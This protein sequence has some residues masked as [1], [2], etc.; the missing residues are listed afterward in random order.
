METVFLIQA[1]LNN[2]RQ[3]QKALYDHFAPAMYNICK[4]YSKTTQDAEDIMQNG[5][6]KV[7]YKLHTFRGNGCFE[8]WMKRI[9]INES[10]EYSRRRNKYENIEDTETDKSASGLHNLYKQDLQNEIQML[11]SGYRR[12]FQ[13]FTDGYSHKEIGNVLQIA[14]SSSKSQYCRARK[15]LIKKIA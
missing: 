8:G 12:V 14:E 5:F 7:F 9:F 1:C 15:I 2:N 4:K 6:M 3:A 13:M 11:P 10:I